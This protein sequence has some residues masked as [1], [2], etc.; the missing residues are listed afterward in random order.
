MCQKYLVFTLVPVQILSPTYCEDQA[1]LSDQ[2]S[3][4]PKVCDFLLRLFICQFIASK[5]K[6]LDSN[7]N[8]ARKETIFNCDTKFCNR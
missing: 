1:F 6:S 5:M 8:V 3:F 2:L 7:K 4:C